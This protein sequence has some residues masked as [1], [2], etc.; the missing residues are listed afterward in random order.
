MIQADEIVQL[1]YRRREK[2]RPALERRLKV[3]EQYNGDTHVD[4][5]ELDGTRKP[6]VAN[7]LN[8]GLDGFAQRLA[9]VLPDT[10]VPSLREGYETWDEKARLSRKAIMGWWTMNRMQLL[11]YKRARFLLAYS[12]CPVTIH[13]VS[14]NPSD[15]RK[16]PHWRI[17]S[18]LNTYA[19]ECVD[20]LDCEPA[21]Y[22]VHHEYSLG[23][24]EDN[25]PAQTATLY[26][27][28]QS[29]VSRDMMFDV[30]EYNDATESVLVAI[31][32]ERSATRS[33]MAWEEQDSGSAA[34]VVLMREDNRA[35]VCNMVMPGRIVL[36]R[37]IGQFDAMLHLFAGQAKMAAYEEIAI[38]RSIFPELYVQSHPNAPTRPK[39]IRDADGKQGIV[40]LI[41]NGVLQQIT[42]NPGAQVPTAI[43]RLE[44]AARLAA[45]ISPELGGESPT[46][47]RTARRG[48]DVLGSSI[49]MPLQESQAILASAKEA[50]NFRAVRTMKGWHG[51][52]LSMFL[53]PRDGKITS[54]P[55]NPDTYKPNDIFVTDTSVVNYSFLGADSSSIPIEIGQR[56]GTG[57]ISLQTAR[58]KDPF[59]DD[60]EEE[61]MRT[62]REGL[63][64]ALLGGVE[65]QAASGGLDP[66]VIARI[67]VERQ[68][69]PGKSFAQV[70]LDVHNQMQK[71]QAAQQQ[72]QSP[73]VGGA[74]GAVPPT[75]MPGAALPPGG[76]PSVPPPQPGQQNLQQLVGA[77]KAGAAGPGQ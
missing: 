67:G 51:N 65:Q 74:P 39:I 47:V 57:E 6:S 23:W 3:L 35:E 58:E 64:K 60:P 4:L 63:D 38:F 7:L 31:G 25:F 5:P 75:A 24:L 48:A 36:D 9:S 27:G 45:N 70:Y 69:S 40:G 14:P 72:Q 32:K 76:V 26:K 8:L 77:L 46:N 1:F 49:D 34:T 71:E 68:S 17:R 37:P 29:S 54:V 22:V 16:I 20:E 41:E 43:D 53:L 18:P 55:G 10:Q 13:P 61:R 44:R 66:L 15:K 50:E 73:P 28:R 62:E 56:L 30:L 21:D 33:P 11:E 59:V 2:Q 42:P 52:K 19:A 12:C